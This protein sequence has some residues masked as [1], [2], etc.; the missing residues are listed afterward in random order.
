MIGLRAESGRPVSGMGGQ[1]ASGHRAGANIGSGRTSGRGE[2]RAGADSGRG[3][4]SGRGG[5]RVGAD[6]GPGR[7][8][9]AARTGAIHVYH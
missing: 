9:T 4:T 5:Q 1:P 2:H 6:I 8:G 7:P 3:R